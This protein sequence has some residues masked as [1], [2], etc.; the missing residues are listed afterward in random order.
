MN[1]KQ[2]DANC[3]FPVHLSG[4]WAQTEHGAYTT[5]LGAQLWT[6]IEQSSQ[7]T[8][9]FSS[10]ANNAGVWLAYQVDD[11]PMQRCDL[12]QMPLTLT[13]ESDKTHLVQI[14]YSGNT[15]QDNVWKRHEGLYF[16]GLTLDPQGKA[17]PVQPDGPAL[18]FIGDSI[19]AGSWLHG[20]TAGRD[21]CAENNYAAQIARRLNCEDLRIAYPG[22]GIVQPGT[23]GVP[24]AGQ[25]FQ[26]V[27]AG[28]PWKPQVSAAVIINLGT[29]D[30]KVNEL[31]FRAQWEHFLQ[32]I[33]LAYPKTPLIVL[34]P[35]SQRHAAVI[36]E[37]AAE[38]PQTQI[39]ETAAW[40]ISY[41]DG[42]HPDAAG[43][44]VIVERLLPL[45]QEIFAGK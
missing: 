27:A 5:N 13:F 43:T 25:F 10:A 28:Y 4:R 6:Q 35:F 2:V 22:A 16:D 9:N 39:I 19:T 12:T 23:G 34:V 11:Q 24:V 26:E 31:E 18:T 30:K 38:Y 17:Q 40:P 42:L 20:K 21:Y 32:Q 37:E 15:I 36:R 41:T 14:F 3:D 33:R 8:F 1:L 29:T 44:K 7:V 45:V